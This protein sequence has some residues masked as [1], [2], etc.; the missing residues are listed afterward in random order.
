M[1]DDMIIKLLK[2]YGEPVNRE[3]YLR[4]KYAG[5]PPASLSAEEEAALPQ[6]DARFMEHRPTTHEEEKAEEDAKAAK[7]ADKKLNK[8]K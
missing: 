3:T 2:H 6:N 7:A 8:K 5:K 1:A 4:L